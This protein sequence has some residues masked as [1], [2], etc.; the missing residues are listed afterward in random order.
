M[1]WYKYY[2]LIDDLSAFSFS[3]T[4]TFLFS[5]HLINTIDEAF[6]AQLNLY[7]FH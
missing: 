7:H 3:M 6:I 1:Y 2:F 5:D 4:L